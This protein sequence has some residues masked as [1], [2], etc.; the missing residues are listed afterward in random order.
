MS[1]PR[2]YSGKSEWS[3]DGRTLLYTY[4]NR[5]SPSH[6]L[7]FIVARA[8]TDG[9]GRGAFLHDGFIGGPVSE[10]AVW[11]PDGSI[12]AYDKYDLCLAHADGSKDRCLTRGVR[13]VWSPDGGRLAFS[14]EPYIGD[15]PYAIHTI[16]I[17][18][19]DERSLSPESVSD[20]YEA[21]P[22]WSPDGTQIA[23]VHQTEG[24][25]NAVYMVMNADGSNRMVLG[26]TLAA[27]GQP[28]WSFDGVHLALTGKGE[29]DGGDRIYV[30]RRDGT[31]LRPVTAE[32]VCCPDWRP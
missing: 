13:P 25:A 10:N 14:V 22:A 27:S 20:D 9:S 29:G 6:S 26:P 5:D 21:S 17:D 3:P 1:R 24:A 15:F 32:G 18:G 19:S 30:I 2:R 4:R 23:F 31:D 28:E 7:Y 11:S 16:R 8:S 12:V